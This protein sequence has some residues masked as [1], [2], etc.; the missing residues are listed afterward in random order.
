MTK[1]GE[2]SRKL[3]KK[4]V[5]K[6]RDVVLRK[7]LKKASKQNIGKQNKNRFAHIQFR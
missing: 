2:F 3:G 5:K 6:C 1:Y 7:P 4:C